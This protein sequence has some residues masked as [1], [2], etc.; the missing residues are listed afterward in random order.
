MAKSSKKPVKGP[1]G[2]GGKDNMM[3]KGMAVKSG[4]KGY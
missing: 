1:K 4:K 2:K 3:P